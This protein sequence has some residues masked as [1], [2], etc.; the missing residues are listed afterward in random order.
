MVGGS[1]NQWT[2]VRRYGVHHPVV[3]RGTPIDALKSEKEE[4]EEKQLIKNKSCTLYI[5]SFDHAL[6]LPGLF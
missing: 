6:L 4:R 3:V 5:H 2:W 1:C